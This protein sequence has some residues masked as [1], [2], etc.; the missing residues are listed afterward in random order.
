MKHIVVA[1]TGA[2]GASYARMLVEQ[3][4]AG[5]HYV[6]LIVSPHG[7]RMLAEEAG[8]DDPASLVAAGTGAVHPYDDLGD[9][10]ASGSVGTDAMVICPASADTLGAVA[11]GLAGNLI[12]RAAH[13]HLK[14]HRRLVLVPREMPMGTIYLENLL[15]LSRAGAIV[16][17]ACPGF[18]TGARSV[19]DL[20]AFVVGR[21]LDLLGISHQLGVRYGELESGCSDAP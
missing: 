5:G 21:I 8:V 20:V 11:A 14:E 1:V 3:I 7:R 13:V 2:S 15:R 16:A 19:E 6:H 17:P 9:V 10:L 12:R 18:Y 4:L